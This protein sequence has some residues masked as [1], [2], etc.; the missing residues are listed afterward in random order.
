MLS[1]SRLADFRNP[2]REQIAKFI[3]EK[4][5]GW[6]T[7]AL[8]VLIAWQLARIAWMLVPSETDAPIVMPERAASNNQ[9]S[10]NVAAIA[11]AHLFGAPPQATDGEDTQPIRTG[12]N[13]NDLPDA[14]VS[15]ALKGTVAASDNGSSVAIIADA[16]KVEKVYGI[17]DTVQPGITIHEIHAG[18][19]V[20]MQNGALTKLALPR[21]FPEGS[22]VARRTPTRQ[23][24]PA[25]ANAQSIQNVVAQNVSKLADVIRPTPYFV[26]GQQ[27]GYRV[28]PGRDRR[29]FAA[30]GLRPGDLIKDIDGAS[31]TDP[32]QA[33]EIFQ[34][35]G[36]SDQV[37]VTV[38]RN[39]QP[40]VLVLKTDQ[41]DMSDSQ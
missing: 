22:P 40:Q 16:N 21:E 8:V 30:L 39:G 36:N 3:S 23:R 12:P 19:V 41:L 17:G 15:F 9:A 38:E 25:Q 20:L 29:K 4:L 11:A 7:I 31:L 24:A 14:R 10:A 5:P 28:Y 1:N 35:L 27:Q 26:G 13:P 6:V 18:L 37:S 2:D 32:K 33:M 34:N